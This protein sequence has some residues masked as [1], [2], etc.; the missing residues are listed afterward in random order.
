[1][2][3]TIKYQTNERYN[4]KQNKDNLLQKQNDKCIH[5]KELVGTCVELKNRLKA[6][7]ENFS[8]TE[9]ENNQNFRRRMFFET[10]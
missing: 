5:F 2:R 8:L 7:Q 3:T 9:T 10:T 6:L 4:M 1:M